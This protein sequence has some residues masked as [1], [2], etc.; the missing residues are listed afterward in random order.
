MPMELPPSSLLAGLAGLG[1]VSALCAC[2]A[3]ASGPAESPPAADDAAAAPE[4][5]AAAPAGQPGRL[6]PPAAGS[7]SA[8]VPALSNCCG[9]GATK[10]Q[11][12]AN[13][14]RGK[15]CSACKAAVFC[16]GECQK[17]AWA[18]HKFTCRTIQGQRQLE[19]GV[20]AFHV[21][22]MRGAIAC[23]EQSVAHFEKGGSVSGLCEALRMLGQCYKQLQNTDKARECFNRALDAAADKFQEGDVLVALATMSTARRDFRASEQRLERALSLA[24]AE[25]AAAAQASNAPDAG[26]KASKATRLEASA[27]GVLG[28][29]LV[30]QGGRMEEATVQFER[31]FVCRRSIKDQ[32]FQ[33]VASAMNLASAIMAQL[34]DRQEKERR[35]ELE[36]GERSIADGPPAADPPA[37]APP[38]DAPANGAGTGVAEE[39]ARAL[40]VAAA[41]ERARATAEGRAA[42]TAA[43]KVRVWALYDEALHLAEQHD[44]RELMQPLLV[45]TANIFEGETTAEARESAAL[46][47]R[48][49]LGIMTTTG[50]TDVPADGKL[51]CP[52]CLEEMALFAATDPSDESNSLSVL[53]C[54]HFFHRECVDKG[55]QQTGMNQ[56]SCPQCRRSVF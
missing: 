53:E 37:E 7:A 1:V 9:C 44:L 50:R 27:R 23:C 20:K 49:L 15:R 2:A 47:R 25:Q 56:M 31:A 14:V 33:L 24:L 51:D 41:A 5:K 46:H 17:K 29:C 40:R 52:I 38:T 48:K 28:K 13:R 26:M 35:E 32:P 19:A 10:A 45:T 30:A 4:K 6:P 21:S 43:E 55:M 34:T 16:D 3:A 39:E 11:R 42:A 22:D 12:D 54:L 18:G 36:S 8:N